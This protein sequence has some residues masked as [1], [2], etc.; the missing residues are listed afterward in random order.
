[1]NGFGIFEIISG[2]IMKRKKLFWGMFAGLAAWFIVKNKKRA[3]SFFQEEKK[4]M[5]EFVSGKVNSQTFWRHTITHLKDFFIPHEG[6]GHKPKSLHSRALALYLLL[7]IFIKLAGTSALFIMFP[8]PA[9]FAQ[10]L[11]REMIVLTNAEREKFGVHSLRENQLLASSALQKGKD[12]MAREYFAHDTPEGKK[13]WSWI[14][15]AKYDFV[16]A[17]ENLAIDFSSAELVHKAFIKSPAHQKNI[18]NEKYLDIGVAVIPGEFSGRKTELL[19]QFFGTRRS[20]LAFLQTL[21][22]KQVAKKTTKSTPAVFGESVNKRTSEPNRVL[23]FSAV[24]EE[25]SGRIIFIM[26]TLFLGILIFLVVSLILNIIIKFHIQHG[27]VIMQ[28][29]AAL[30]IIS[31]LLVSRLHFIQEIPAR[32]KI[33]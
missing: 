31:I 33:L 2:D 4:E 29:L 9:K 5:K 17:G 16:Y 21:Q 15:R 27:S 10:I 8:N 20:D 11:A 3:K 28:A 24:S 26:N 19:V 13:P 12:M 30:A 14:D 23:S 32:I 18:L 22:K 1:M 6:N 7:A 25:K